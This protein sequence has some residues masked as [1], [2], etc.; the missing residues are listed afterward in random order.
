MNALKTIR[1]IEMIKLIGKLLLCAIVFHIIVLGIA[2][3]AMLDFSI[4]YTVS[5]W[6]KED[7]GTYGIVQGLVLLVS[8]L[9]FNDA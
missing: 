4:F 1:R 5:E 9:Y 2:S 8:F 3:F 6:S 7:R